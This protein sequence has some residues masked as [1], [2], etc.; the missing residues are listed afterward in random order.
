MRILRALGLAVLLCG[1]ECATAAA[2]E[3]ADNLVQASAM[4]ITSATLVDAEMNECIRSNRGQSFRWRLADF[5]WQGEN[6]QV[7][8]VAQKV[9]Q[10]EV[11]SDLEIKAGNVLINGAIAAFVVAVKLNP[12]MCGASANDISSGKRDVKA[13]TP[14]AFAFLTAAPPSDPQVV[15]EQEKADV[16]VGCIKAYSNYGLRDFDRGL[17]A[18]QCTTDTVYTEL[19][20]VQR[21]ELYQSKSSDLT[22]L[23]WMQ[24]V[25][26]KL[27][28]CTKLLRS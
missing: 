22:K 12:N 24:P 11:M 10:S 6:K 2:P 15:L 28:R 8:L 14:R 5:I 7:V 20:A 16:T 13:R 27:T 26:K 1:I 23:P 25:L 3:D 21:H 9:Y 18:C 19:T 4:V 17:V